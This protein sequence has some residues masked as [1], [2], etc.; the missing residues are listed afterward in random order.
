MASTI[1]NDAVSVLR[2]EACTKSK[3]AALRSLK[4][5]AIGHNEK[6]IALI[7]LRIADVLTATIRRF[8]NT[9]G[10]QGASQDYAKPTDEE[11]ACFHAIVLVNILLNGTC[12]NNLHCKTLLTQFRR[13]P[14][15]RGA[16]PT[17]LNRSGARGQPLKP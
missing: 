3:I 11:E 7:T 14:C 15:H 13:R 5:E 10:K 4:N 16:H 6:K 8:T 2:S 12:G 17:C 9:R 1:L